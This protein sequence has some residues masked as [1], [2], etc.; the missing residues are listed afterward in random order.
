MEAISKDEYDKIVSELQAAKTRLEELEGEVDEGAYKARW[1]VDKRKQTEFEKRLFPKKH[2]DD[3][4]GTSIPEGVLIER[5]VPIEMSDGVKLAANV[6]RPDKPPFSK[7][8]YGQHDAFGCSE[9]TPFE[10][11]TLVSWDRIWLTG[12]TAES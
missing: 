1:W 10:G 11:P 9:M 2:F 4:P 7:D 3:L 8:Y 6:F 12:D 5:D